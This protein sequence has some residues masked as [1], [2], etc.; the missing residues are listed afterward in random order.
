MPSATCAGVR[1]AHVRPLHAGELLDPG[2][3]PKDQSPEDKDPS[4]DPKTRELLSKVTRA[5]LT[6]T[7][8]DLGFR[9]DD[10]RNALTSMGERQ[11]ADLRSM[12]ERQS[13]DL[14]AYA[15]AFVFLFI[16]LGILGFFGY[17]DLSKSVGQQAKTLTEL[18][19]KV[20]KI[21]ELEL[22][23]NGVN[24]VLL[25]LAGGVITQV[26]SFLTKSESEWRKALPFFKKKKDKFDFLSFFSS[27]KKSK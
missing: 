23:K 17:T 8:V 3:I 19:P 13:A 12:G 18:A 1:Q 26:L 4:D 11:S 24:A 2:D 10:L 27:D 9:I 14:R 5:E 25:L 16:V 15:I 22:Y 20:S 21:D 6:L 7:S